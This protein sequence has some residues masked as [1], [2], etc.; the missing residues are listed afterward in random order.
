MNVHDL[1]N[2]FQSCNNI[3]F[4]IKIADFG[5]AVEAD[6]DEKRFYGIAGTPIYLSPE[7]SF[8]SFLYKRKIMFLFIYYGFFL[9]KI[10]VI[11]FR[12][13]FIRI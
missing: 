13:F 11:S 8:I 5:L 12:F 7:V 4:K 9:N 1:G 2:K 3:N 10:G 6:G